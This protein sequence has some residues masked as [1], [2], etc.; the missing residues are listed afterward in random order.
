MDWFRWHHGSVTDQ[1]FQLVARK[2]GASVAEVIAVWA[3]LLESASMAEDRG[4]PG[5]CD[6]EALDCALGMD[7][8]KSRAIYEQMAQRGVVA[9]DGR[10]TRWEKRQPKR[11]REDDNSTERVRAFRA[12]QRQ[13]TPGNAT[14]TPETP[15]G[16]KSRE[17]E[18]FD[19]FYAAYPRKVGKDA[20]RKAFAKRNVNE[21]L[22]A[23]MVAAIKAQGLRA[24]CDKGETQY[25]PHP[26]TW[27][28]EGRWEDEV[29]ATED[30]PYGIK[31][32]INYGG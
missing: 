20:A 26:S 32:A 9:E 27:L 4:N 2:A 14:E 13:E 18:L 3:S 8:G 30:D 23:A 19:R 12:K 15:R 21:A 22:L 7:E 25:V 6:F 11:E 1:K 17:E 29:G 16:D 31:K 5:E 24:K 28:S 10:I